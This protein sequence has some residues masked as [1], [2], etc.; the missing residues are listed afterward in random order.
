MNYQEFSEKNPLYESVIKKVKAYYQNK[1]DSVQ[2]LKTIPL[3]YSDVDAFVKKH[4]INLKSKNA[5]DI[6]VESLIEK[7]DQGLLFD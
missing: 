5:V 4:N 6:I 2:N 3:G 7:I 1:K